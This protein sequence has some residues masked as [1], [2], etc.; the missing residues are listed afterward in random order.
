ML[1]EKL[2]FFSDFEQ[3]KNYFADFEQVKRWVFLGW[4]T[5]AFAKLL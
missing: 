2:G 4:L 3:L 5:L 1:L